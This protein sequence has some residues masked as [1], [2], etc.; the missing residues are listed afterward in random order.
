MLT[1][2]APILHRRRGR[3]LLLEVAPGTGQVLPHRTV[4]SAFGRLR[5]PALP[6]APA[7]VPALPLAPAPVPAL[8]PAPAPVPALPLAPAPV[9]IIAQAR[10]IHNDLRST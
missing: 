1:T 2:V 7:P 5:P 9:Y 3:D 6:P 8:P 10:A 4:P